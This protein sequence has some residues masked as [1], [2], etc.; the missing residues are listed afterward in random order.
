MGGRKT[1]RAPPKA[2][3]RTSEL[4][5]SPHSRPW[6]TPRGS[7][8]AS[9]RQPRCELRSQRLLGVS[10]EAPCLDFRCA[11]AAVARYVT[12]TARYHAWPIVSTRRRTVSSRRRVNAGSTRRLSTSCPAGA[13]RS[14]WTGSSTRSPSKAAQTGC[15]IGYGRTFDRLRY[16]YP[17]PTSRTFFSSWAHPPPP[18]G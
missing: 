16:R 6:W 12:E 4:T 2:D 11:G 8:V 10:L 1:S 17:K 7:V 15:V 3:G 5:A 9:R 14:C 13:R 18:F